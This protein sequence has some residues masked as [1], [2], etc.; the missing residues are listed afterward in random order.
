MTTSWQTMRLPIHISV[1][2]DFLKSGNSGVILLYPRPSALMR[3][4]FHLL[5]RSG[6]PAHSTASDSETG[7]SSS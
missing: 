5:Y 4:S 7:F 2:P 3:G 6:Y 1:R